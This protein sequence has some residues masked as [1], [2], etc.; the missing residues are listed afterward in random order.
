MGSMNT[1]GNISARPRQFQFDQVFS[2]NRQQDQVYD[3]LGISKLI[4]RVVDVSIA[5]VNSVVFVLDYSE[6]YSFALLSILNT[7][8][9]SRATMGQ[10]SPTDR[11]DQARP[12]PWRDVM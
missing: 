10:F 5:I 1:T 9:T 6:G 11:R 12:T 7:R 4:N 3:G 2:P 8:G